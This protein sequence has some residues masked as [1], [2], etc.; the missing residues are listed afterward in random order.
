MLITGAAGAVA[1]MRT[2]WLAAL[3]ETPA[4]LVANTER[5]SRPSVVWVGSVAD[6]KPLR[7]FCTRLPPVMVPLVA[8]P[9]VG[10]QL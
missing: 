2:S 4:T 3:A 7:V 1:S 10:V 5:L 6:H 8:E 9:P